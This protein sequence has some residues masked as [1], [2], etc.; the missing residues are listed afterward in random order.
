MFC[1]TMGECEL[2]QL[3]PR[4]DRQLKECEFMR[5][6]I[7]ITA[8]QIENDATGTMVSIPVVVVENDN[9]DEDQD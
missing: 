4:H 7:H 8:M 1:F 9:C 3:V 5:T 2:H 6:N